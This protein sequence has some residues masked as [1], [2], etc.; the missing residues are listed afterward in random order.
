MDIERI[1]YG[2]KGEGEEPRKGRKKRNKDDGDGGKNT[3][4][5]RSQAPAW[6]RTRLE[7]LLR[8]L[9]QGRLGP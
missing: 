5:P 6:E 4:H 3:L 2:N 8:V 9:S 1:K 7:A